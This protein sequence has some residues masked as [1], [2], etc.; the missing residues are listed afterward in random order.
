MLFPSLYIVVLLAPFIYFSSHLFVFLVNVIALLFSV[1]GVGLFLYAS[2]LF[3]VSL[4]LVF[5]SLSAC[6]CI[7]SLFL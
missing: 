2:V 6:S 7:R 1:C 3:S 5:L 4:V